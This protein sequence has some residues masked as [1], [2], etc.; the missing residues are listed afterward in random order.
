M[1]ILEKRQ[2]KIDCTSGIKMY[3]QYEKSKSNLGKW[4]RAED[5]SRKIIKI[6]GIQQNIN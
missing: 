3:S 2:K 4:I 6:R 1:L 5:S